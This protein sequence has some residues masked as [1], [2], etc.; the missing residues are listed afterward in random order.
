MEVLGLGD[1]L[2]ED[3]ALADGEGDVWVGDGEGLGFVVGLCGGVLGLR[4]GLGV[5]EGLELGE[6]F[7]LLDELGGTE[8]LELAVAFGVPLEADATGSAPPVSVGDGAAGSVLVTTWGTVTPV[9][10]PTFVKAPTATATP[11]PRAPISTTLA[12]ASIT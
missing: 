7:G 1:V 3:D 4:V 5:S 9:P 10:A 2:G 8:L 11:A 6:V 12:T